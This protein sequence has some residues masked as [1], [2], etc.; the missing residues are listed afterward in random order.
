MCPCLERCWVAQILKLWPRFKLVVEMNLE[1][2]RT[3]KFTVKE[4][5]PTYVTRRYNE[6]AMSLLLLNT[7]YNDE[8]I[9]Q[10]YPACFLIFRLV[11]F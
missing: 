2:I 10:R 7:P 9:L 1:S 6:L 3:A 4:V 5:Q 8:M 11:C